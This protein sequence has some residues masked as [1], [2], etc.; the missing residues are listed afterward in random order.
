M[1]VVGKCSWKERE[2]GKLKVGKSEVEKFRW[3]WK[4][5]SEVGKNR[6]KLKSSSWSWK[7][8]LKLES[9]LWSWKVQT[10]HITFDDE[11]KMNFPTSARTFRLQRNFPTLAKLSNFKRNFPTSIGSF[12][13]HSVLSNFSETFQLKTFQRLVLSNCLFQLHAS[14][15]WL[16]LYRDF[17]MIEPFKCN[18]YLHYCWYDC[19]S[20]NHLFCLLVQIYF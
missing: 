10:S 12:Q 7:V 4:E 3:S 11:L 6:L 1:R 15:G 8:Q 14:L 19:K 2:V 17:H 5:P 20:D 9:D 13:L 16:T 18:L